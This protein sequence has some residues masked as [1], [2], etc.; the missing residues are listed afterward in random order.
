ML[1]DEEHRERYLDALDAA[2]GGD[3]KPLVDLFTDV[4]AA[5]L[6]DA[7]ALIG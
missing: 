6:R 7:L 1:H 4:Q 3:L 2:D 5:D